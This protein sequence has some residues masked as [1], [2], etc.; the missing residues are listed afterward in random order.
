MNK[1]VA[2]QDGLSNLMGKQIPLYPTFIDR[3]QWA[4]QHRFQRF[5]IH[6]LQKTVAHA[7]R[8]S[9]FYRRLFD[10]AGL[11]PADIE[12]FADLHRIPFTTPSDLA[13]NPFDFLCVSQ[14]EIERIITFTSSG[15]V[16]PK[17]RVFFTRKDIDHITNFLAVGMNTATGKDSTVQILLPEGPVLGQSDLLKQ[18]VEKMGG[19]PVMSGLFAPSQEQVRTICDKRSKVI[20]GE[21][22]LIYRIS[23]ETENSWDLG[24]LGLECVFVTT[25]YLP[26]VMRKYFEK[27]YGCRVS[28]HYG[29][30]EMGLGLA[31]ECPVT[32]RYHFNELDTYAEVVDPE[33]GEPLKDGQEGELV[34]TTLTRDGMP[35]IRYRSHDLSSMKTT[36][37]DCGAYLSTIS[38]VKRRRESMVELPDG[39]RI[40]PSLFD[41]YLFRNESVIDF[42]IS[43]DSAGGRLIFDVETKAHAVVPEE[44][45]ESLIQEAAWLRDLT[46]Q[47]KLMP[48]GSLK[49]GAHFKKMI[50]TFVK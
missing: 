34:F 15:T 9:R 50:K 30:S 19:T 36:S 42:D 48:P 6:K 11:S 45:L 40:Y 12:T 18:G 27:T 16:G 28:T 44:Q 3:A 21:T 7:Y 4:D 13:A 23:K 8:N 43:L 5:R 33:T 47:V 2:L 14:A 22:R 35:L 37:C 31:V 17:K 46:V 32:G 1:P 10:K 38:H 26:D 29:L 49:Q 25:S 20:F 41:D 24:N 39:T